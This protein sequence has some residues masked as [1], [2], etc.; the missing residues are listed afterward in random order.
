MCIS[1]IAFV[2]LEKVAVTRE[3]SLGRQVTASA[4]TMIPFGRLSQIV[5]VNVRTAVLFEVQ[6]HGAFH[7]GE[8]AFGHWCSSRSASFLY[9]SAVRS[10][11]SRT[12]CLRCDWRGRRKRSFTTWSESRVEFRPSTHKRSMSRFRGQ[13]RHPSDR[14]CL[15]V[16]PVQRLNAWVKELASDNPNSQAISDTGNSRSER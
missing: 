5:G 12:V 10:S 8:P 14:N 3:G 16:F 6:P 9:S 7:R 2:S 4:L 13:T 15:G 1:K 11:S